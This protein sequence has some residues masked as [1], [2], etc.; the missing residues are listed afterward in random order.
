MSTTQDHDFFSTSA[1]ASLTTPTQASSLAK[2]DH[3]L[4]QNQPCKIISKSTSKPGKHGHAKISF[5]ALSLLNQKKYTELCPAHHIVQVPTVTRK[6]YLVIDLTAEGFLSLF[7]IHNPDVT[8]DDIRAPGVET[9]VG[10]RLKR[11]WERVMGS[12][13]EMWVVVL[14]TMG[15]EIVDAVKEGG[16]E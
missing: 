5:E 6:E 14:G 10:E 11:L 1:D 3:I 4:I 15:K 16:K 7:D 9:E 13:G 2:G 12:E 8:K